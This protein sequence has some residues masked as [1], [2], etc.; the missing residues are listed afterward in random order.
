MSGFY[1]LAVP[2]FSSLIDA[3]RK[4]ST[5]TVHPRCGHYQFVEFENEIEILRRDTRMNEAV[6]FGCLTGGLDGKIAHFDR[7]RLKLV[8]TNEP[9]LGVDGP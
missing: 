4:S 1:V 8:A 2:E 3:A 5:C 7:D 9:I 6:W